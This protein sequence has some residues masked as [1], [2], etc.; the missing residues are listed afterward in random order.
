M[1]NN[2]SGK[3]K[4]KKNEENSTEVSGNFHQGD[5]I[6]GDK[7]RGN[8]LEADE[9]IGREEIIEQIEFE[10]QESSLGDEEDIKTFSSG[11]SDLLDSLPPVATESSNIVSPINLRV[12]GD[13]HIGD[14]IS[15]DKVQGHKIVIDKYI[16]RQVILKRQIL[17]D[18]EGIPPKPGNSPYKGL[19]AY[20]KHD[21]DLF[22]GREKL[23]VELVSRLQQTNLLTVVGAS[24]SGKS[25]VVQ[26]GVVPFIEQSISLG[27]L[28]EYS[29]LWEAI[30]ITPTDKPLD[31]F[32]SNVFSAQPDTQQLR[33]Q[34][35][36]REDLLAKALVSYAGQHSKNI[37][38]VVD[39]F[40]ELFTQC[41]DEAQRRAFI[42]NIVAAAQMQSQ[43]FKIILTLR[44]DFY[45]ESIQYGELAPL[46]ETHQ[47]I[48]GTMKPSEM[49]E[50]ILQPAAL[51]R[52]KVL[53]GLVEE[54]IED[55][56]NEPGSLPLLSHALF[57]TWRRRRG[58]LMTL[59][60]YREA[61]G[62]RGAIA[63]TAENTYQELSS[64]LQ[65]RTRQIF[66]RLTGTVEETQDT[67][68]RIFK[69]ELYL[70]QKTTVVIDQLSRARLVTVDQESVEVAHEAVIREWPR[71]QSWLDEDREGL[72]I[73]RRL[74]LAALGWDEK[75]KDKSILFRG[76]RLQETMKW[77]ANHPTDLNELE[78]L[79]LRKSL[80]LRSRGRATVVGVLGVIFAIILIALFIV[81]GQN[82]Q[83]QVETDARAT[84]ESAAIEAE[85]TAVQE[86]IARATSEAN[87]I[88]EGIRANN[89]AEAALAA[90]ATAV[91][92]EILA[93]SEKDRANQQ[94]QVSRARE[95]I[96][97]SIAVQ[98]IDP[99]L[100]LLL[101]IESLNIPTDPENSHLPTALQTI[102]ETLN[103]V[104]GL[105]LSGHENWI[106]TIGFSPDNHWFASASSLDGTVF[107]WNLTKPNPQSDPVM[108]EGHKDAVMALAFSPDGQW[109][110][111]GG[112]GD[113]V[114][115][116][117]NLLTSLFSANESLLNSVEE[118]YDNS[119]RLWSLKSLD[120]EQ[121]P[122]LLKGHQDRIRSLTMS[123]DGRW[124]VSA[125]MDTTV[126]VWDMNNLNGDPTTLTNHTSTV[127]T[128]EI[129]FD[130]KWL[131]TGDET[132]LV[133]LWDLTIPLQVQEPI[134][135]AELDY[136]V[137]ASAISPDGRWVAIGDL[138]G[139]IRI[140]EVSGAGP[141][142]D[143][144]IRPAHDKG[145]LALSFSP[146][147]NWFVTG[148]GDGTAK[149]WPWTDE[150][151]GENFFTTPKIADG[152]VTTVTFTPG[153]RWLITTAE[154]LGG[155]TVQSDK[156]IRFWDLYANSPNESPIILEGFND[157]L[158]GVAVSPDG[159]W[160]GAGSADQTAR[161]WYLRD[162]TEKSSLTAMVANP[163]ALP[164]HENGI[165]TTA[166]SQDN[167]WLA[168]GSADNTTRLWDLSTISMT[169]LGSQSISYHV[170]TGQEEQI[171]TLAF[172]KDSRWLATGSD[173]FTV[174]LWD[175]NRS[176]FADEP[177]I[178]PDHKGYINVVDFSPDS[179]WL[180]TASSDNT[181]RLWDLTSE[182]PS[183]SSIVL[184]GH[185]HSVVSAAFSRDNRWLMTGSND[186]VIRLWDLTSADPSQASILLEGHTRQI[187]AA[188]FSADGRW[189]VTGSADGTARLWDL[190]ATPTSSL[191]LSGHSGYVLDVALSND[192]RWLATSGADETVRLWDLSSEEVNKNV[193][194]LY[195]HEGWVGNVIFSPD[196]SI[197]AS[198]SF[199]GS[200][201]LWDLTSE[202]PAYSPEVLSTNGEAIVT[203]AMSSD[204]HWLVTGGQDGDLTDTQAKNLG[205][206]RIWPLQAEDL[207][208]L[209]CQV[210]GRNFSFDEW[211]QYF[212]GDTYRL[213][214]PDNPLHPSW[215]QTGRLLAKNGDI[216]AAIVLFEA[217]L[218]L[219]PGLN[220]RPQEEANKY[221][222]EG[223]LEDGILLTRGLI[224]TDVINGLDDFQDAIDMFAQALEL[225]PALEI[226][227]EG[228]TKQL[229][230]PLLRGK[231]IDLVEEGEIDKGL[232]ALDLAISFDL[233]FTLPVDDLGSLC[234]Y[235]GLWEEP[236]AVVGYCDQA[237]ELD[238]ERGNLYGS[239][240]LVRTLLGDYSGA[241]TDFEIAVGWW[242]SIDE[243]SR[244]I[245]TFEN[246]ILSLEN[247]ENP[248]DQETLESLR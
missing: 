20:S 96:A 134:H 88:A 40:E 228:L 206:P 36:T 26:A 18:Y 137:W 108:L 56:A 3:R 41:Q 27:G 22:F 50:A 82:Q 203:M 131:L 57:E 95:I 81:N 173:D 209:A 248:I 216:E 178:L 214:C 162:E 167:H 170:L 78:N 53:D 237:I 79:F 219:E 185:D 12:E 194:V 114:A 34:F 136:G 156:V 157:E 31:N 63:Q 111:T 201:R 61:G 105:G 46:L 197:L 147:G 44:S 240:G 245:G 188:D 113:I 231:A 103:Q 244:W 48:V 233:D 135:L 196:S 221:A 236:S 177:F 151:L 62:V 155:T 140:W 123:P 191:Q 25:S 127:Q 232:A 153:S 165:L 207:I 23:I 139:N 73:H 13:A 195:G 168:T 204:A 17:P 146:D 229:A 38:F 246:W 59:T 5:I 101:A 172:S 24:G 171:Y 183:L 117:Q 199:D 52:W 242:R 128:V 234:W 124:L 215:R 69:K 118:E 66:K 148:S 7:V 67:R 70:D 106:S 94:A 65:T 32:A 1:T 220:L 99:Q 71:L 149:I 58:P 109:L 121:S 150:P 217:L 64:D 239:R 174:Y 45:T 176:D 138:G 107:L 9:Y 163:L 160:L 152:A 90:E 85:A 180:V 193:T 11:L 143:P 14:I 125:S 142:G 8:L 47:V 243:E 130:G 37:L 120:T 10:G 133:L 205:M 100:S 184:E 186:A 115:D 230:A 187:L 222:A 247:G 72:I 29:G 235:G 35:E 161:L 92:N 98:E 132:G 91:A 28:K 84:S 4:S 86:A 112:G 80:N 181:A 116:P 74:T 129:S 19:Q 55:V 122:I 175:L 159:H 208:S 179:H 226:E 51:G 16:Q 77:A 224:V 225:D 126:R 119:I 68:R 39:Q 97:Q 89:E 192:N 241:I 210:A 2:K 189:L 202:N 190:Q 54:M 213:T 164:A 158:V 166:I 144:F 141:M 60:G 21:A 43:P 238:P 15:G 223:L 145:I 227:P 211:N 87:A 49:A 102:R 33:L 212:V 200:V 83:L 93:N 198:G 182:N 30:V 6:D 104:G 169:P 154:K 42:Q 218:K 75:S 110:A 76:S